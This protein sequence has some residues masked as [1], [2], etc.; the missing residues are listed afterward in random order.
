MLEQVM[1]IPMLSLSSL[2]LEII[3]TGFF[4]TTRI[5]L[6]APALKSFKRLLLSSQRW[7]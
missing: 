6:P 5:V 1:V 3:F 2:I 7:Q 4:L